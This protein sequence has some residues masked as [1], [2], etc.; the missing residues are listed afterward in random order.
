MKDIN[1][2][3]VPNLK[4]SSDK[5]QQ[6]SVR[7]LLTS[8]ILDTGTDNTQR[9]KE[10]PDKGNV[11]TRYNLTLKA[12]RRTRLNLD[13]SAEPED[14]FEFEGADW[15]RTPVGW[16]KIAPSMDSGSTMVDFDNDETKRFAQ[17]T[18]VSIAKCEQ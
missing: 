12:M 14:D 6:L 18:K 15:D 9:D 3:D 8:K 11:K 4:H 16:Q 7:K 13:C 17:F 1:D 5:S 2:D 10:P